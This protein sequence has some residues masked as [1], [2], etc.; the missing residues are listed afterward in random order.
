MPR[1]K[2]SNQDSYDASKKPLTKYDWLF[3][4]IANVL[5]LECFRKELELKLREAKKRKRE[6]YEEKIKTLEELSEKDKNK[7]KT[8]NNKVTRCYMRPV[9]STY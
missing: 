1:N 6:K 8:F 9:V 7:W 2:P 5:K 4:Q 3:S